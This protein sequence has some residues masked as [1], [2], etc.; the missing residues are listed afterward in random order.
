MKIIGL[1]PRPTDSEILGLGP[2]TYVSTSP[3]GDLKDS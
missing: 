2:A 3:L 1:H